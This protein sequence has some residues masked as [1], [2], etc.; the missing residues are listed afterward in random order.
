MAYDLPSAAQFKAR[1]PAFNATANAVVEAALSEAGSM[2]DQTW[3]E[4]DFAPARMYLAAHNLVLDGHG[5]SKEAKIAGLTLAGL[6]NIK[7]GSL[8]VGL[9]KSGASG[10]KTTSN[11]T[12]RS[13]TYGQRFL[14]LL[15]R[16]KPG[17]VVIN[18]VS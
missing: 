7:I 18:G 16:N 9:Q 3:I 8:G 13:T 4:A 10:S 12:Y 1:F 11:S 5:D 14:D 17:V 6:T 2:V 15:R